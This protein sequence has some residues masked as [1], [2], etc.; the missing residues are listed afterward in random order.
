MKHEKGGN[1]GYP[2]EVKIRHFACV[3]IS[4]AI[5]YTIASFT[6]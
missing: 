1:D 6:D 2:C 4:G 5:V 3:V